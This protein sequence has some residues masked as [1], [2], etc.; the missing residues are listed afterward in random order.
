MSDVNDS[1]VVSKLLVNLVHANSRVAV[2][3]HAPLDRDEIERKNELLEDPQKLADVLI[4]TVQETRHLE[5]NDESQ[6]DDE[7]A[8]DGES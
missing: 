7:E 4:D 5:S 2:E 6:T 1:E 3:G 8:D